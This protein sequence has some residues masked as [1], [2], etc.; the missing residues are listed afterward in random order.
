MVDGLRFPASRERSETAKYSFA[1][2]LGSAGDVGVEG[3]RVVLVG[4]AGVQVQLDGD[5]GLAQGE[6]A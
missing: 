5:T 6:G 4:P 2:G 3:D 1:V